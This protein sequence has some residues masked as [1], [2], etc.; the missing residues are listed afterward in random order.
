MSATLLP[1]ALEAL[2]CQ[3]PKRPDP[4]APMVLPID[5]PSGITSYA[6]IA[7][8]KKLLNV[9]KVGHAGTLDPMATG[10]LICL[11]HR[12]ATRHME[13]FMGLGKV[14]TGTL[15]L[16]GVT[17]SY[18]AETEVEDERPWQHITP[19]NV[20]HQRQQFVGAI[21]QTPPMYSA[22]KVGGER[23]YKKARRGETIARKAR[24]VTV[25]QYDLHPLSG[26]DWAFEIA[27]SKGTY[28]R[29]LV[30]DLGQV[31]GTG[32]Y[33]TSLRRT[34][35]GPYHVEQAWT[36]ERLAAALQAGER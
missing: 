1:P 26:P 7:R 18:D 28:V 9:K 22:V 21:A 29:S 4:T 33:M 30:H 6:V 19:A 12:A 5:K 34:A 14:Y 3:P 32:A 20:E 23:L 2:V 17:P 24:S 31:L 10:L 36:L 27:C 13:A 16:G 35:I 11:V 15:R 25:T 8:L